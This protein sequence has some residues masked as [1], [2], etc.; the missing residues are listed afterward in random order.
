MK[1]D[2]A[3]ETLIGDGGLQTELVPTFAELAHG[4]KRARMKKKKTFALVL[5]ARRPPCY[6]RNDDSRSCGLERDEKKKGEKEIVGRSRR[7]ENVRMI[8][9]TL[10]FERHIK[11]TC[12]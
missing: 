4:E 10:R 3:D 8:P 6:R 2:P 1:Q 7:S 9:Q 5:Q 12:S 11:S